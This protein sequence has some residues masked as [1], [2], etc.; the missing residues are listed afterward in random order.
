MECACTLVKVHFLAVPAIGNCLKESLMGLRIEYFDLVDFPVD[1]IR[2]GWELD[3]KLEG[4]VVII[5]VS[6]HAAAHHGV[7]GDPDCA[8]MGHEYANN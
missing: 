3:I 7:Q 4:L 2:Q 1:L 5:S 6:N 8:Y